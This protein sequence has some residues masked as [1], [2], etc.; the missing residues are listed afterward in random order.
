MPQTI[1]VMDAD[2]QTVRGT[3][4]G[5]ELGSG[6]P[7]G[8]GTRSDSGAWSYHTNA[9]RWALGADT[10]VEPE[11][12]LEAEAGTGTRM[13]TGTRPGKVDMDRMKSAIAGGLHVRAYE[14]LRR[15]IE[16]AVEQGWRRAHKHTDT[17]DQEAIKDRIVTGII[18]EVGEYFDS[19]EEKNSCPESSP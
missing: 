16:E 3:W 14:V 2:P 19:D 7:P 6:T 8:P 1:P 17:P 13:G 5:P 10:G 11:T 4:S 9:K 18:A 15:A 12:G